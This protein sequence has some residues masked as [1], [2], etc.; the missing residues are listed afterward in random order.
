MSDVP[1]IILVTGPE[2]ILA[3][4]AVEESLEAITAAHPEAEIV[5]IDV[6]EYQPG[7]LTTELSP[8]LFGGRRVIVVRDF[9]EAPDALVDELEDALKVGLDD[10][11]LIVLHKGGNRAKRVLDALKKAK[12]RVIEAPAIKSDRDKSAF[13]MNEFRRARRRITPEGV[14][15][16]LE[17]AGKDTSELAAACRQ[18]VDDT[19]GIVDENTVGTYHGGKVEATGFRVADATVAGNAP[20]ALRLLRHAFASGV[21]PVPIVAVLASQLR[22]VAKVASAGS[23]RSADLAK[24]LGMPPW[25]VD[26]AR[27]ASRGWDGVRLG[28]AIQAVAAADF[29]VK[30]GGRDPQYAVEHVVLEICRQ[31]HAPSERH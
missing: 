25:Q 30:G 10:A 20:E 29:A 23:G 31:R 12:A 5:R 3:Q 28:R 4:R 6:A 11:N 26:K 13:V 21:D 24:Q 7:R 16:L 14:R 9:D 22:Q 19:S 27:T 1:Q 2:R 15:A 8:S 17:A 18:L